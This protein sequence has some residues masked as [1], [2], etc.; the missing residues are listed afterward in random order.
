MRRGETFAA[1]PVSDRHVI[2]MGGGEKE[3]GPNSYLF[4]PYASREKG[5]KSRW[6][7]QAFDRWLNL[8]QTPGNR[9]TIIFME[10]LRLKRL[11][12]LKLA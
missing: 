2:R 10:L 1:G 3:K 7:Y 5:G 8:R 11:L 4:D 12:K 6:Q 9:L